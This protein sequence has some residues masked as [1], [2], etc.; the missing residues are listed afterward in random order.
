MCNLKNLRIE[1][2][3]NTWDRY[4]M[5]AAITTKC[6][7]EYGCYLA[8]KV[9]N[10]T[11]RGIYIEWWLHNI[12]YWLTLPFIKNEKV[13]ALNERFKHVDLEEHI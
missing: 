2:S 13:K 9:L 8:D 12:G 10:R 5:F 7:N 11:Y 1:N 3:Y 4:A 6:N